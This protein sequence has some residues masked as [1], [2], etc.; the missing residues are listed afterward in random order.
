MKT[1]KY[2]LVFNLLVVT[3]CLNAQMVNVNRW[4]SP[5]VG[6]FTSIPENKGT[7]AQISSWGY[8]DK[9]YQYRAYLSKPIGD[10]TVVNRWEMPYCK[11]F[12]LIAEHEIS[13]QQMISFGYKNKQFVFYAYRTPPEPAKDYVA[14]CRWVNAKPQG[15]NCRDFTLSVSQAELTDAQL[16]SWGYSNVMIQFY[17]P[18]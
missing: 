10:A 11:E 3:Y 8:K 1:L 17:V 6:D 16:K 5:I 4:V 18:R 12:I 2:V 7:D 9:I 15:D 13:D 14:V